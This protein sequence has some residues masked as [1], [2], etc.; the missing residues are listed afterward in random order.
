M[1]IRT[2]P[3]GSAESSGGFAAVD[4]LVALTILAT[5][6]ALALQAADSARKV[7]AA[8][9]QTRR[10]ETLLQALALTDPGQVGEWNGRA[11]GFDWRVTVAE[12]PVDPGAPGLRTCTRSADLKE[13]GGRRRFR[14]DGLIYCR[15]FSP[16][17]ATPHAG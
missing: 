10:A 11:Q 1:S 2:A 16:P 12:A 8:A 5:T 6:I 4:A 13:T 17:G 15:P 9:L 3:G 7:A 14:I